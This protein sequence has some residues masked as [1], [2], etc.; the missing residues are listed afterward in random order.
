MPTCIRVYLML[1]QCRIRG[2]NRDY[3]SS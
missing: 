1:V 2:F 3:T